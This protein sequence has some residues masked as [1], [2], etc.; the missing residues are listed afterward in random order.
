MY[1]KRIP[2]TNVT[3]YSVR[4]NVFSFHSRMTVVTKL[5]GI[6][7]QILSPQMWIVFVCYY[8]AGKIPGITWQ[9]L[10]GRFQV[11]LLNKLKRVSAHWKCSSFLPLTLMGNVLPFDRDQERLWLNMTMSQNTAV[12]VTW[13]SWPRT[14]EK[15]TLAC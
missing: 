10:A 14:C 8:Y 5:S 7:I 1:S 3:L 15:A 6:Y 9:I 11:P 4:W 2:A 12:Y 13:P